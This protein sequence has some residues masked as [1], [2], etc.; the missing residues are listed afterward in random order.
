MTMDVQIR[1]LLTMDALRTCEDLQYRVW[2][3]RDREIVPAAQI[4]AALHAGA[5]VAGAFVGREQVGFLYG[6]P[7]FAH[8][9]GL[10]PLGLHSHM[11]AVV[12]EARGLGLGRRL[13]WY[14]RR[15]C[16]ERG[17]D[18]VAW[19]FDPLQAGNA[20]LNLEHLGVV[21]HE[22][23]VDFY[24]VLGG[25]LS[26]E[27]PTDRFVGLWRLGSPRVAGRAGDDPH[28]AFFRVDGDAPRGRGAGPPGPESAWALARDPARDAPGA[29][30]L[31]LDAEDVWVAAPR[32]IGTLRREFRADAL[33]WGEAFR[34]ASVDL[35]ERGY[36][37]RAFLDGAYR[38]S[39]RSAEEE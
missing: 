11:M 39:R 23:H 33:A 6:F 7:A 5:L 1:P 16:L 28:A 38:W 35:V 25:V 34:A 15:W 3:Y 22:Y 31:G 12:P 24:G 8:E 21:V 2:G 30:A 29:V 36:E 17:I 13:K 18:W 32:D 4:R 19:T 26:G 37:V 10:R 27:L 14:Q 9:P 20:R